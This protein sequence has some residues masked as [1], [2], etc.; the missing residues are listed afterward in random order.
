MN[1]AVRSPFSRI[2]LARSR[3][4]ASLASNAE[5][6]YVMRT[7]FDLAMPSPPTGDGMVM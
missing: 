6:I 1:I 7:T 2:P 3:D 5:R 4:N